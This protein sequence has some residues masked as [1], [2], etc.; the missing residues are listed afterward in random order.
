MSR[1]SES[2]G[3]EQKVYVVDDDKSARESLCW[4]LETEGI[5]TE[6]FDSAESFLDSWNGDWTGCITVDIRMPGKSG[7]QLQQA[8]YARGNLMPVIVL[9]GHA[10]VPIAIR[11]MKQ[12]AHDFLQKPYSDS[13]LLASVKSALQLGLEIDA[14]AREKDAAVTAIESLTE[15]ERE[16]MDLVVEGSTNKAVAAELGISEKTVEVH[17]A[18][19]MEKSGASSLSELVR[20]SV[21]LKQ[22]DE[23]G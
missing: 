7:L 15:R 5:A 10:D 14:A 1:E 13:E 12:G 9:T 3:R 21:L 4:L 8:L 22:R 18:R 19:V 17:R 11:A 16:V 23:P 20:M 6:A 2:T